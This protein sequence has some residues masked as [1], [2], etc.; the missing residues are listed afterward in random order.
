MLSNLPRLY[1]EDPWI[2]ALFDSIRS[3]LNGQSDDLADI[4]RQLSLDTVT[5]NIEVEERVAGITPPPDA[6]LEERRTELKAKWRSGGR[7]TIEQLQA[8]ADAWKDGVVTVTF[9]SGRIHL[10][11]SGESG[12]P[13]DIGALQKAMRAIV[14]AHLPIDY[15]LKYLLV[16]DVSAMTLDV[17]EGTTLDQFA[18]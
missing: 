11:F 1:R 13:A 10:E 9:P 18:F 3:L 16:R 12:V 4:I 5:W 15:N 7:L 14:P 2:N 17:L 8:V 6:T